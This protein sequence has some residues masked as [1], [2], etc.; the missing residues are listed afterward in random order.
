MDIN[1]QAQP[2]SGWPI[3]EPIALVW[4]PVSSNTLQDS[5]R[6]EQDV[7]NQAP[8]GPE[9]NGSPA[10]LRDQEM[11]TAQPDSSQ[12]V[13]LSEIS[14]LDT[15]DISDEEDESSDTEDPVSRHKGVIG[16]RRR[17]LECRYNGR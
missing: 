1:D 13:N 7:T 8:A 10:G 15:W 14:V 4:S 12:D 5:A 2:L 17:C 9:R 16:P 3:V 6:G 11:P